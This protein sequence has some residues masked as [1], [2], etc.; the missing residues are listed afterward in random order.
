[1]KM[2]AEKF[3]ESV[4][5]HGCE[6]IFLNPGTDTPPLQEAWAKRHKAGLPVPRLVVCPHETI[7]I[8]AAQGYFLNSGKPQ[9]AFVHVDVGTANATG[10][11]NDARASQIPVLLC[12]GISPTTIDSSIPGARTKFINWQQDVP[13][14]SAMVSNYAKWIFNVT[15]AGVVGPA[16]DRA[17]QIAQSEPAGP[18]YMSFPRE[19]MM[20]PISSD[21]SLGPARCL[22]HKLGAIPESLSDDLVSRIANA[23]FPLLITGYGGRNRACREALMKLS[24]TLGIAITEYRGRFN[25]SLDH[26]LHLGFNPEQ[27]VDKADLILVID[28]DVPWVPAD[29]ELRDDVHVVHVGPDPIKLQMV[30]WGFPTDQV[31]PCSVEAGLNSLCRSA[32][33]YMQR[34]DSGALKQIETRRSRFSASHKEFMA[35]LEA[36]NAPI[37]GTILPYQ[38]GQVLSELCPDADLIEE[39]VTSGNPFAYGYR[40]S[41]EGTYSR[42]GGTF[43]G[44]GLGASLG[45]KMARPDRTVVTVVGDGSFMFGI[46][47]S[48]LWVSKQQ[49]LPILVVILNNNA[50]NSV[51]LAARDTY[52]DGA[53]SVDGWVGTELAD[54]PEFNRLADACGAKGFLIESTDELK[55]TL[56]AA[57]STV[58][59][60]TTAV[61]EIKIT[62]A[63]K[64]L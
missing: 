63:D 16:V 49:K 43:L 35:A 40:P 46:P 8:T 37:T 9:V 19:V 48:A 29:R 17:Y 12:A 38:V 31:V 56:S 2:V 57:L 4:I 5:E 50:Y 64:P 10:G 58:Q 51:K 32:A 25:T 26:D 39:A 14:Q 15:H 62:A 53:M 3:L 7:A 59:E 30:I 42:N 22:P 11:L 18:V 21:M 28:H 45:M 34:A 47:T 6:A 13:D 61:V 33:D 44:W 27:W 54:L 23:D 52:P 1:M 36:K 41:A 60:G 20:E 55:S 24:D